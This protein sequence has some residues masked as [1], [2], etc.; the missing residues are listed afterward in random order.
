MKSFKRSLTL[1]LPVT[2]ILLA[3]LAACGAEL[4]FQGGTSLA[5]QFEALSALDPAELTPIQSPR[6][7]AAADGTLEQLYMEVNPSVVHIEVLVDESGAHSQIPGLP[8]LPEGAPQGRGEGSGFVWDMEG[9]IVTNNHVVENAEKIT[10]VF[11]DD[12]RVEATLAGADPDSDLAVLEVDAPAALLQPV[13]LGDSSA[14]QVGELAIAIGNPF[15]QEGTMTVGIISALGRL[16]PVDTQNPLAPRFNIPDIIQTDAA[17]NP[18]NSGG[19]LLND[20][21]E[22]IGVTTAIISPSSSSSG[23]GFAIPSAITEKVVPALIADGRYEHAYLGISGGSLMPELAEAMG[24]PADQRGTLVAEVV[25][26]GP[27]E[28]AGLLGSEEGVEIDGQ[29]VPVGGDVIIAFDGQP[30]LEMDDLIAYLDRSTH[31][32]QTVSLTVLRQGEEVNVEV[33]LAARPERNE[34]QAL[35]EADLPASRAWLGMFGL[36]L[37]PELAK[38]LELPA[39]QTGILVQQVEADSPADEAGLRGSYK[40]VIIDGFEVLVGGDVIVA[41]NGTEV[42]GLTELLDILANAEP[43]DELTLDLLRDGEQMQLEVS[44]EE[45]PG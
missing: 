1:F 27:A 3:V 17:I 24:L 22:V 15:G 4:P 39:E 20:R 12:T 6:L 41:V 26:G 29:P 14:L 45:R 33:T 38:A 13:R 37:V 40:P 9:H 36:P 32:G 11:N 28:K 19:V 16:L 25:P 43:G 31:V 2:V 42:T 5:N 21:G 8:E 44:L 30:I 34:P 35:S 7:V 10:V 18:G 23:I